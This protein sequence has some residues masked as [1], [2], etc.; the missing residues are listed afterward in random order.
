MK[1]NLLLHKRMVVKNLKTKKILISTI[2]VVLIFFSFI[3]PVQAS[4]FSDDDEEPTTIEETI[5]KDDGGLFEKII[6]KMIRRYS[7]NSI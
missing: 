7:T 2:L 4:L 6:A 1:V 3:N 5:E